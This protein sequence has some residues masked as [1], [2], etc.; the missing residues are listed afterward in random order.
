MTK[1]LAISCSPR[2]GGNTDLLLDE[3]LRGLRLSL[4]TANREK[5][6]QIEKICLTRL[7]IHPCTQCDYCMQAGLCSI[8]DDMQKLYPKLLDADWLI[9][10]SPI[11][12]MAHCAQAKLL[13]DRCQAF[14]ARRYILKQTLVQ[15]QHSPRRGIFIAVGATRGPKVFAGAKLTMKY[16]FNAVQMEY[17]QDLLFD[18]IEAKGAVQKNSVA[19]QEAYEMGQRILANTPREN[20]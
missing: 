18:G 4:Q 15:P 7:Q 13:I 8:Q 19:L 2:Q 6:F 3:L 20:L 9:L 12:F 11:Y 16:F 17:W 14:W 10:A 5:S 1:L